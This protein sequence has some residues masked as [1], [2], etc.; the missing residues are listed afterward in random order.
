MIISSRGIPDKGRLLEDTRY[1]TKNQTGSLGSTR[2]GR[3]FSKK[4]VFP[5]IL[6][7]SMLVMYAYQLPWMGFYWDDWPIVFLARLHHPELFWSYFSFDRPFSTWTTLVLVPLL[8]T[9]PMLWQLFTIGV[10]WLGTLAFWWALIQIWPA[11]RREASWMALLLAAY[12]AFTQQSVSVAYSQ[13]FLTFAFYSL[14]LGL[15]VWA[16]RNPRSYTL[17]TVG[18]VLASLI[19]MFTM[20]YFIGLELLR[21]ILI[22]LGL[23]RDQKRLSLR[24][25]LNYW[26]PYLP[27][28]ILFAIYRFIVF[29]RFSPDPT[30]NTPSLFLNLIHHPVTQSLQ[31]VENILQDF[32]YGNIFAWVNP[33]QPDNVLLAAKANWFSWGAGVLVA[34]LAVWYFIRRGGDIPFGAKAGDHFSVQAVL[35]GFSAFILGGLPLWSTDRQIIVGTWSDRF[36]LGPM[37]GAAILLVALVTW[38]ISRPL[39]QNIMIGIVFA[40][41]VSSQMQTVNKYRLN[42]DIQRQYYWEMVW[43][44]PSLAP[45]TLVLAPAMPFDR[46]ADYSIA[47]AINTIYAPSLQT[48]QTPYWFLSALRYLGGIIPDFKDGLPVIYQLRTVQF[49]GNTS[50]SVVIDEAETGCLRVLTPAEASLPGL[51]D[52][53]APLLTI[54]HPQN[55]IQ[56]TADP[57]VPPVSIYGSEPAHT[58]CYYYEK[59]D[60]ARQESDW[61]RVLQLYEEAT[62]LGFS[63]YLGSELAPFIDAYAHTGQW[64]EA[65]ALTLQA[66]RLP[67]K[68]ATY[69]CT[70]WQG[71]AAQSDPSDASAAALSN[72]QTELGCPA[73]P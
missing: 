22:A 40:M 11:H 16:Q 18:G 3:I 64:Q 28:L 71:I 46:V 45:G 65:Q 53:S 51:P 7:V 9:R 36:A 70:L 27:G 48:T 13:H 63:P 38:V 26:W 66:A 32:L 10:R 30:S 44:A 12:P 39:K 68:P 72:L 73:Q 14:S 15:M 8:G 67:D 62:K 29:P 54:S 55:V 57:V 24:S 5:L 33:L 56:D 34:G 59:A 4:W 35:V 1:T 58:W 41:A 6:L 52:N 49:S 42:W 37:A 19:Q 50:Q 25:I 2:I 69:L 17:K 61:N 23:Q 60:L 21:P 43:R 31:I 20:E 47:F